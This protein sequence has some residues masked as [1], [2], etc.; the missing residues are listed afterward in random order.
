MD[1]G[2]KNVNPKATLGS[3]TMTP[4]EE[5]RAVLYSQNIDLPPFA[6]MDRGIDNVNPKATS[7][8]LTTTAKEETRDDDCQNITT[9][10]KI[11]KKCSRV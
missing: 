9:I 8:G 2:I 7:G 3:P 6:A 11:V 4:K 1:R 5:T 10:V